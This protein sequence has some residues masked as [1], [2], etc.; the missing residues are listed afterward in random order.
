MS[1][2]IFYAKIPMLLAKIPLLYTLKLRE[3]LNMTQREFADFVEKYQ[4]EITRIE[5][6]NINVTFKHT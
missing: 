3:S 6:G 2:K 4:S 1:Y 5:N